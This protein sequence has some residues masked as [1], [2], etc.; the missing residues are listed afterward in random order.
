MRV[1]VTSIASITLLFALASPAP[2][3]TGI[4]D[5]ERLRTALLK[6]VRVTNTNGERLTGVLQSAGHE[7]VTLLTA[8]G[9]VVL[10]PTAVRKIERPGDSV[11]NGFLIGALA[12][13]AY[14]AVMYSIFGEETESPAAA[15][16]VGTGMF[17]L[18]G[19]GIDALH[20]GWTTVY[21]APAPR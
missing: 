11:K 6:E 19:A 3:Q 8:N 7:A 14:G 9:T 21:R 5:L 12:G 15:F 10:Q 17:G 1:L 20:K 4:G 2:G 18:I 13:I 16:V